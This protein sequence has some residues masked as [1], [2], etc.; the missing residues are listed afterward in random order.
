M[1]GRILNTLRIYKCYLACTVILGSVSGIFRYIQPCVSL[2]YSE[3]W[4]I[5][6]TRHVQTPRYI[7]NTI[8]NFFT[9]APSST[10]ETV[11]N[12][13]L[14]YRCQLLQSLY[15]IFNVVFQTYSGMFNTYSV[16]FSLLRHIKNPG[17]LR[18]ILLQPYHGPIIQTIM[19]SP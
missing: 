16:I 5:F 13:P 9:K 3:P 2:A 6:I 12:V 19:A 18:I 7:H 1:F 17:I 10:F 15:G 14:F 8:L 11:L 4:D